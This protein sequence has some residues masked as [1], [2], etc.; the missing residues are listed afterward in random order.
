MAAELMTAEVSS[1]FPVGDGPFQIVE[2]LPGEH[3]RLEPNPHYYRSAAGLPHLDSIT[4]K[5]IADTNQRLSLLLAGECQVLT[6]DGLDKS[7]LTKL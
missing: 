4:F 6:H 5:F 3:I 2:W 1:R 7:L